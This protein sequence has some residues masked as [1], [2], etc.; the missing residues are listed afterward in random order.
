MKAR[1]HYDREWRTGWAFA[2]PG[3]ALLAVV[4]GFP[5][6][7]S[8][9]MAISSLTLLKPGLFPLVGLDN[10]ATLFSDR[11]FWG[12]LLLTIRYSAVT[13][14]GE[15][16]LGLAI[17]L[18]LKRAVR[19]RPVYFGLLTIPMAMSP[20]SVAL[21]WKMLLQ[22]NLGIVNHLLETAGLPRVDW[23]GNADLALSTMAFV[24]IWQQTS[25]VVLLLAA[26]L[27][28]LPQEPYE[29]AEVD[30]A[31]AFQ[32]FIYITLPMLRPVAGIAIIIQLINEF[33]TYDL[34]YVLT[35]GGPGTSTE[36]LSYFAYRKAFLG[37]SL[38]QG[39]AAAFCLLVIIL[40]LTVVFF[41]RLE[42]AEAAGRNAP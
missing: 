31:S 40:A 37:L 8:V 1:A 28:A 18:M 22:P 29:A 30:G 5:L 20:I 17:A 41:L 35:R 7:Y 10:F 6:A 36:V 38:N 15:F 25:F 12:A 14:I 3:L 13:V 23:L 27:A 24:D 21:I 2:A 39:A 11:L 42:R 16:V 4:M 26:G 19:M 32:Q 34:P 33:R 9:L